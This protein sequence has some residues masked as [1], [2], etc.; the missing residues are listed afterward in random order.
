[1]N[2]NFAEKYCWKPISAMTGLKV[3]GPYAM[4]MVSFLLCRMAG[5]GR[6]LDAMGKTRYE[7]S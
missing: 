3:P 7:Q 4:E 2:Y 1:V 5:N 6:T